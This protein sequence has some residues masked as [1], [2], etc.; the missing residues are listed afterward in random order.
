MEHGDNVDFT[1]IDV[2]TANSKRASICAVGL[3]KVRGGQLVETQSW[4]VD[5]PGGRVFGRINV[6]K[7][8]ITGPDLVDAQAWPA[9]LNRIL[10]FSNGDTLAH[11]GPFDVQAI[12]AAC[13]LTGIS[14]PA[15]TF[16]DTHALARATLTL[17]SFELPDVA[18]SLGLPPFL[19]HN[20]EDDAVTC[21]RILV[22]LARPYG[23]IDTLVAASRVAKKTLVAGQHSVSSDYGLPIW[24][25]QNISVVPYGQPS[26]NAWIDRVLAHPDG[27]APAGTP[28]ILCNEP[29]HGTTN[30]KHRDRHCCE[31]CSVKLK[32]R[33]KKF[34]SQEAVG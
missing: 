24:V 28:C 8:G 3:A 32:R 1:A 25:I 2:E 17:E 11:H 15:L 31:T 14:S 26:H 19:H 6:G 9:S 18:K 5:P 27:R 34:A 33:A 21:A 20:A 29:I 30:Y 12:V 16:V 10:A 4:L 7:H 23:S 13:G 22:A